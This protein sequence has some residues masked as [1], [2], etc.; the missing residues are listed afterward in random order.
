MKARIFYYSETGNTKKVIEFFK[1]I[2]ET[3]GI[4]TKVERIV[5]LKEAKSFFKKAVRSFLKK[6]TEICSL[7]FS[8]E[9]EV[10]V[11]GSP[12]WAFTVPPA[13]R[14]F[15]DNLP[16]SLKDK[17]II[18]LITYGSGLGKNRCLRELEEFVKNKGTECILS[19]SF[20]EGE[21]RDKQKLIT[22]LEKLLF[23]ID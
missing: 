21:I 2:L 16:Q 20:Q 4:L 19:I 3:K 9:E 6:K 23:F 17:K 22:R 1:D 11:I 10:I 7:D 15:L 5:P 18:L 8:I 12:V 14:T 13:V